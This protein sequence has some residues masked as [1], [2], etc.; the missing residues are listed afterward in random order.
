[1]SLPGEKQHVQESFKFVAGNVQLITIPVLAAIAA[2][3][4]FRGL[5]FTTAPPGRVWDLITLQP[6]KRLQDTAVSLPVLDSSEWTHRNQA[7]ETRRFVSL[8]L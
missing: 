4:A 7:S 8:D 1:M 5:W 2:G 3:Q 6:I